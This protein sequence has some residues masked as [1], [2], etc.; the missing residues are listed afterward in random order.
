MCRIITGV[1][2]GVCASPDDPAAIA[3]AV[4]R[5]AAEPEERRAMGEKSRAYVV[6]TYSRDR[7]LDAFEALMGRLSRT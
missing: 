5:L 7:V 2:C 6:E 1:G 3:G 4:R